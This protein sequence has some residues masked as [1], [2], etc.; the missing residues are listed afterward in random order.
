MTRFF[1]LT[2]G[3]DD[4]LGLPGDYNAFQLDPTTV[5]SNDTVTGSNTGG[6][7]DLILVTA[8]GTILGSQF[9]GV[10]NIEQINLA[11]AG[12]SVTLTD[13]MVSGSSIGYFAVVGGSGSNTIDASGIT[14]EPIAFFS[15]GGIDTFK[16]GGGNDAMVVAA[17]DLNS[18][19]TIHGGAGVDNLYFSTAGN[20]S[21]S[22]FA[23]VTGI[24][25]IVLANG[26]NNVALSASL[27]AGTDIGYFAVAG[28]TGNDT[29]DASATGAGT[30]IA[31][32]GLAGGD[33][34]FTG[35]GGND[36]FLFAAGQLTAADT[37]IGGAGL[38][39]LW[40]TTAGVTDAT[41]LAH[42]SG[43]EGVYLENGGT[44]VFS[45]HISSAATMAA[46]GT[47]AADTFD[48]SAVTA[49]GVTF[50]GNGGGDTLTGGSQDDHFYISDGNFASIDGNAGIDHI[51]VTGSSPSLDLTSDAARIHNIEVVSLE[52]V[53]HGSVTL[54]G[55]DI[56]QISG[57]NTLYIVSDGDDT[58]EAGT[59]YTQIAS[60][61]TND[62]VAPGHS[63]YEFQHSSGAFLFV[64]SNF[65][66]TSVT[67]G[68]VDVAPENGDVNRVI[69]T[70]PDTYPPGTTVIHSLVGPDAGLFNIDVTTGDV[71][72]KVSPDY[73]NPLDQGHDNHYDFDI[74]T[75]T[76]RAEPGRFRIGGA[77]VTDV[78]D[79]APVFN[80]PASAST[81]EN[82]ATTTPVYTAH[83]V[84]ADGTA[85]NN[86]VRYSLAGGGDNLLFDIGSD[87]GVV[88]FKNSP[89]YEAPLDA[90]HDNQYDI[91][92]VASDGFAGHDATLSVKVF[93]SDVLLL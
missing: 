7:F 79:N 81:P 93:V 68:V 82:V 77:T 75:Q 42:V 18:T 80:S 66:L 78:N 11:S 51:V 61:V 16:G 40:I 85:A 43:I 28:G 58:F 34:A 72:F 64:D 4:F 45:D 50:V 21:A 29:I 26:T 41:A 65:Y 10:S 86:T 46:V 14:S 73:E 8:G 88:T 13:N 20:V 9:A 27:V 69:N 92:V 70:D 91:T 35:G 60:G 71:T 47:G 22:A 83:A 39:T 17:P 6:F 57:N 48:A 76:D 44:F 15:G 12:N 49:Y 53:A 55:A 5:Q 2:S 23:N 59:G 19:D 24:E 32:L 52:N 89:D 3:F 31:F 74:V 90:D 62:Q 87:T 54:T 36:S 33:D 37:V 56:G 67:D 38:D 30:P 1:N 84:D 25:A 63:F